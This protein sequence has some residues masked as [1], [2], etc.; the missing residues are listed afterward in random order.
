MVEG[1]WRHLWGLG[2]KTFPPCWN[3]VSVT[4][5]KHIPACGEMCHLPGPSQESFGENPSFISLYLFLQH[6]RRRPFLQAP[7]KQCFCIL[8][9]GNSHSHTRQVTSVYICCSANIS[10]DPSKHS[11]HR[12]VL[13]GAGSMKSILMIR[14]AEMADSDP[15]NKLNYL[16]VNLWPNFE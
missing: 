7:R 4:V 9:L 12:T 13:P 3:V 2:W 15:I 10:S 5:R 1:L 8:L 6:L 11:V 16:N 14:D